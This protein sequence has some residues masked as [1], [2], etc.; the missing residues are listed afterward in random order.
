[1]NA[2]A[3]SIWFNEPLA[4]RVAELWATKSATQ[5]CETIA[6]EFKIY[7]TRSA[8][9]GR[10]HR[11]GLTAKEKTV[12]H[13]A[14]TT[15]D[16]KLVRRL[17]VRRT[18]VNPSGLKLVISNEPETLGLRCVDAEPRNISLLDLQP[19]DCRYPVGDELPHLFCAQPKMAGSSYCPAHFRLVRREAPTRPGNL[20]AS[21]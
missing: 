17:K 10:I 18:G 14:T 19:N 21:A 11:L 3:N 6:D 8:V 5:I 4:A 12:S 13:P 1:M 9:I 16:G 7:L 15:T 2:P 20:R